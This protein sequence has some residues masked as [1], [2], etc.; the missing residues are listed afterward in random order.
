METRGERHTSTDLCWSTECSFNQ[1]AGMTKKP[2]HEDRH[3]LLQ[4]QSL[5]HH[6]RPH[7]LC[8]AL[9]IPTHPS[10]THLPPIQNFISFKVFSNIPDTTITLLHMGHSQRNCWCSQAMDSVTALIPVPPEGPSA[11]PQRV[12]TPLPSRDHV[13]Y[14][15]GG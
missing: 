1:L 13:I 4:C 5:S 15:F 2:G 3:Y 10:A 6:W 14:S 7:V 8:R 12:N 9:S 11:T